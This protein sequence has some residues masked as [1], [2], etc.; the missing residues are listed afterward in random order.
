VGGENGGGQRRPKALPVC[1]SHVPWLARPVQF[2]YASPFVGRVS[3]ANI[4]V[5]LGKSEA[6]MMWAA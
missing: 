2:F 6:P 3:L 1:A 5:V 4:R